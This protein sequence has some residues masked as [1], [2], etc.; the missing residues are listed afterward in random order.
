MPSCEAP[1]EGTT[2]A[3]V[4][5]LEV[6]DSLKEGRGSGEVIGC[7]DLALEPGQ[8][9]VDLIEPACMDGAVHEDEVWNSALES[10]RCGGASMSAAVVDDPEDPACSAVGTLSHGLGDQAVKA[11]DAVLTF[12]TTEEPEPVDIESGQ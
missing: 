9:D 7:K 10:S 2:D 11:G 8:V 4:V 1:L 12:A 6:Q 5:A 3:L